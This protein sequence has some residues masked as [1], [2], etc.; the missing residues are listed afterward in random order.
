MHELP[1]HPYRILITECCVSKKSYS[2]N[3]K[4][5]IKSICWYHEDLYEGKYQFII[6]K[7]ETTGLKH[8]NGSK[9]FI[10]YSDDMNDIYKNIEEYIIKNVK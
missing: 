7:R 9:A 4:P 8:F 5:D 3:Q 10:E 1:G 6:N 2:L